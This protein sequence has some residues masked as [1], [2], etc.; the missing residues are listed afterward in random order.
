[1]SLDHQLF[2]CDLSPLFVNQA[3]RG[4][5]TRD[6]DCPRHQRCTKDFT[7]HAESKK[8][9][10]KWL[11]DISVYVALGE[12]RTCVSILQK[13][14]EDVWSFHCLVMWCCIIRNS[15]CTRNPQGSW[16]SHLL[17]WLVLSSKEGIPPEEEFQRDIH[18]GHLLKEFGKTLSG[19]RGNS[20]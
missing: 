4:G 16:Q 6:W 18:I 7:S 19:N 13:D 15:G 17:P 12:G 11:R 1:M 8:Y 5:L 2:I 10:L 3:S 9:K 14:Q 20:L